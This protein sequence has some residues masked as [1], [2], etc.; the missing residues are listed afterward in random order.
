MSLLNLLTEQDKKNMVDYIEKYATEG[1]NMECDL[2]YY[3]RDWDKCKS[4][5]LSKLFDD[6]KLI[7][8]RSIHVQT[9]SNIIEDKVDKL[10]CKY[11]DFLDKVANTASDY[12]NDW[13]E[14]DLVNSITYRRNLVSNKIHR[15]STRTLTIERD[16]K[17]YKIDICN[18]AKPLRVLAKV[19]EALG[20]EKEEYEQFRIAHSMIFNTKGFDGTICL[21]IHPLDF[22]T[23]SDNSSNW[24]SCMSWQNRGCYRQGTVEMMNSPMIVCA[25]LKGKDGM[26]LPY[27]GEWNNKRWRELFI[28]N[29]E[30]IMNVK[31]YPYM[32]DELTGYCVDWLRELVT[33]KLGWTFSEKKDEWTPEDDDG[34]YIGFGPYDRAVFETGYMYNDIAE[35]YN[36]RH[37]LYYGT[38]LD[39][40]STQLYCNYSGEFIC[41]ICGSYGSPADDGEG[42][43]LICEDCEGPRYECCECGASYYNED[44]LYWVGDNYYC[45]DCYDRLPVD[46]ITDD[47]IEESDRSFLYVLKK[48]DEGKAEIDSAYSISDR[49]LSRYGMRRIYN[50]RTNFF[51]KIHLV[52]H[53]FLGRMVTEVVAYVYK[54]ELTKEG[55]QYILEDDTAEYDYDEISETLNNGVLKMANGEKDIEFNVVHYDFTTGRTTRTELNEVGSEVIVVRD[56]DS[57]VI[58]TS[59]VKTVA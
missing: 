45:E 29:R 53:M 58:I 59:E 26:A 13:R 35:N 16:D 30:V 32:S 57:D 23:M 54:D 11:S 7:M 15:N 49:H 27:G 47:K 56:I 38:E 33:N 46:I 37:L 41:A 50:S 18:G 40:Q 20:L 1:R 17:E 34:N 19:V 48:N 8:E 28:V 5:Y 3:L 12:L 52:E 36:Y 22:M 42:G 9:P 31:S 55:I 43:S 21:S 51:K 25:Y 24:S 44:D 6:D 10:L 39:S 2:E 4:S 14:V